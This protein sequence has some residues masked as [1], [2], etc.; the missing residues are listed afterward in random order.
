MI[1]IGIALPFVAGQRS[2]NLVDYTG[3]AITATGTARFAA[4]VGTGPSFGPGKT[5]LVIVEKPT[6][7][8]GSN[9]E[10]VAFCEVGGVN[11]WTIDFVSG[12]TPYIVGHGA[13]GASSAAAL[14]LNAGNRVA[15]GVVVPSNG[16][17]ALRWCTAGEAIRTSAAFSWNAP[18][19]S[20]I[21]TIGNSP[22]LT[23]GGP[24]SIGLIAIA[25]INRVLTDAELQAYTA[26]HQ[27]TFDRNHF[28]AAL[29]ADADL[30]F[31][32]RAET[33][34]DGSASTT[35]CSVGGFTLTKTG[36]ITRTDI[37]E[38]RFPLDTS[39]FN[40]SAYNEAQSY[41][42]RRSMFARV[43]L[44]TD[45]AKIAYDFVPVDAGGFVG[46]LD[47][48]STT[49]HKAETTVGAPTSSVFCS[50]T[51]TAIAAGTKTINVINGR[52]LGTGNGA[53]LRA[54]RVP[55][56]AAL[57]TT[58]STA[59]APSRRLVVYGD[60]ISS[61][62]YATFPL[63]E[64]WDHLLRRDFPGGV[65]I[66]AYSGRSLTGDTVATIAAIFAAGM[67]GTTT[68]EFWSA[69]GT[70][71]YGTAA[72]TWGAKLA[73]LMDEIHALKPSCKMYMAYPLV[74]ADIA[75]ATEAAF[76]AEIDAAVAARSAWS[77]APVVVD[78]TAWVVSTTDGIHP[79]PAGHTA[80]KGYVKTAL[81]Y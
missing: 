6:T 49:S 74:R 45:A 67:D 7:A 48:I 31:L 8:V 44:V 10:P 68:N 3:A 26:L 13:G 20:A 51:F 43:R 76:R 22:W 36:T 25:I 53:Q 71:D 73:S 61:G 29:L 77:P 46:D 34:W 54:I 17:S 62:Y 9:V 66:E 37:G 23:Y 4:P 42:T 57:T 15:V 35:T 50:G 32:W 27:T 33:D 64:G 47:L 21:F 60:S 19:A 16:T 2:S 70:N 41:G 75:D 12:D 11:G 78:T 14:T 38:R 30:A 63:T 59:S 55:T 72:A 40:D 5:M 69:I 65:T 1:G 52:Q 18:S 56:A 81:G 80:Y 39:H 28:P 24:C 79:D 58:L